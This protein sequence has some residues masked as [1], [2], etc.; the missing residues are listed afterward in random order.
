MK[1][2]DLELKKVGLLSSEI[3]VYKFLLSSG[4]SSP[5]D[6]AQGTKLLRPN[7]YGVLKSLRRMNLID[8]RQKGKRI[9]YLAK[10]PEALIVSLENKKEAIESILPDLRD[11][12]KSEKNKPSTRYYYGLEEIKTIFKECGD[13]KEILFIVTTDKLF[14]TYSSFFDKFRSD[15]TKQG[16]FIK[17]ILT[18]GSKESVAIPTKETMKGYYDYRV[19]SGDNNSYPTSIRIWGDNVALVTL[20]ESAIGMV[21]TNKA[22]AETFKMIFNVMWS[23]S[24]PQF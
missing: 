23:Q 20:E 7:V 12:F 13:A 22:M 14:T 2:I 9:L 11:L 10:D 8:V 3:T 17:D 18:Y 24:K 19:L 5:P 15:M 6:I 4:L 1:N 16:V 21:I